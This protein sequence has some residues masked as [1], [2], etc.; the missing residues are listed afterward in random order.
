MNASGIPP[1]VEKRLKEAVAGDV[2]T[3]AFA[4]GRY[5]TDASAYQMTPMAVVIPKNRQDVAA[6]LAIAREAGLPVTPR[7]AGTSQCGQ[8]VNE[9][10]IIDTSRHMNKVIYVDKESRRCI[11]EPGVVLDDLNRALAPTGLWFPVDISTSSRATIGGMAGNNSCGGRSLRYG[12]MRSNVIAI[13]AILA[14][15]TEARFAETEP[16]PI[17]IRSN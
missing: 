3:D 1:D 4:R 17:G 11:V 13:D 16:I 12:T 6:A 14:D 9:A 7:G 15:G 2:R 10:I 5:A 8:T